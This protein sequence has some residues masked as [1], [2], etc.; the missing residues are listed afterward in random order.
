MEGTASAAVAVD[1][2]RRLTQR[3]RCSCGA[4]L[5]AHSPV[6]AGEEAAPCLG[7]GEMTLQALFLEAVTMPGCPEPANNRGGEKT[8]LGVAFLHSKASSGLCCLFHTWAEH[9]SA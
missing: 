7:D 1:A 2:G 4:G 3:N 6:T 8:D 9:R 5:P